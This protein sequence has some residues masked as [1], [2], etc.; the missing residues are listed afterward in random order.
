MC[1]AMPAKITEMMDDD[2]AMVE[3]GG[4]TKEI[5]LGLVEGVGIGDYVIIHVGYAIS[6][7]DAEEAEKTLKLFEEMGDLA[8]QAANDR[9][10][11]QA[12]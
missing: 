2:M 3:V 10:E 6:R 7:L 11:G 1:L 8:E 12:V 9:G 5:S 4:V